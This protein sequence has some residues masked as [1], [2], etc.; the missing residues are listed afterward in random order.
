MEKNNNIML[1]G[2]EKASSIQI[3]DIEGQNNNPKSTIKQKVKK[4]DKPLKKVERRF[5]IDSDYG[6]QD[7]PF[8]KKEAIRIEKEIDED[9][10]YD[11]NLELQDKIL[12]LIDMLEDINERFDSG[13]SGKGLSPYMNYTEPDTS[14]ESDSDI[15]GGKIEVEKPKTKTPLKKKVMETKVRAEKG[16]DKAKEIGQKLAEARKKKREESGKLTVKELADKKREEKQKLRDEKSKPWYYVGIIPKG[17]R[18]A[19]EDEAIKNNKVG[20]YGKHVV[21]ILKYEFYEKY[22]ILLSYDLTDDD[23]RYALLGI[24]KKINKSFLEIEILENKVENNKYSENQKNNFEN[25]LSEEKHNNKNLIKAYNWIYKLYCKRKNKPYVKRVFTPPEK[26]EVEV[27]TKL[28][29]K[30]PVKKEVLDPRT[31]KLSSDMKKDIK[32]TIHKFENAYGKIAIPIK[33]FKNHLLKPKYAKQLYE[34]HIILHPEH[35]TEEDIKKY[36]YNK[37]GSGIGSKDAQKLISSGYKPDMNDIDDYQ[38]DRELS[39]DRARVYKNNKTGKA[40]VV[41][42]GTKESTDWLNNLIY[43][44]SPYLYKYTNRYTTAQD[45]QEKALQK[46]KDVDVIGHSQGAKLAEMISKGDKRIKDVITYNRPVGPRETLSNL[47]DNV[48][49]IKSSYD[50]VSILAPYQ[51]GNKPIIIDMKS[52]NPLD[53]HST[54]PFLENPN[55]DIGSVGEGLLGG[56]IVNRKPHES[57]RLADIVQSVIFM[58]PY[59]NVTNAKKWLKKHKYFSDEIH[60]SKTQIRFRQ[61]NPEDLRDRHF[62]SKKLKDENILLI[63]S[64]MSNRGSGFMLDNYEFLTPEEHKELEYKKFFDAQRKHLK[65]TDKLEKEMKEREKMI[66]KSTKTRVTKESRTVKG[67]QEAKD[68][69]AKV[70]ASKKS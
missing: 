35:Y 59:W 40:Y 70:R 53:Q 5:E 64:T 17:Y 49:D 57:Q 38:L 24:P 30:L 48:T 21:D 50:P 61:Y 60:D 16:S 10:D 26:P 13:K 31:I 47:D 67:S 34:K 52:S 36:F 9:I 69:M 39:I 7:L 66:R 58:K 27:Q 22:N 15:E 63:I 37:I 1:W 45:V 56:G 51:K 43:T 62:I 3:R 23:I 42:R 11:D 65:A 41:H 12:E 25:K 4:D 32:E 33:A 54:K 20:S 14:D 8:L 6:V 29:Y 19:T 68:K 46:Y 28:E 44:L 55:F 2:L 18:E